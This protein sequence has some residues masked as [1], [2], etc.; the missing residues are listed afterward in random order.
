MTLLVPGVLLETSWLRRNRQ[1]KT[2]YIRLVILGPLGISVNI[3][4]ILRDIT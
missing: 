4:S 1:R 2:C 3:I